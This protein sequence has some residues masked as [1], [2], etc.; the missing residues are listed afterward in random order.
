[1]KISVQILH[2]ILLAGVF[3]ITNVK[4]SY[5]NGLVPKDG[6][7]CAEEIKKV[8]DQYDKNYNR[9]ATFTVTTRS[10]VIE[11]GLEGEWL[12]TVFWKSGERYK[13]DNLFMTVFLD[14]KEHVI[15]LKES[16]V[17][18]VR[19]NSYEDDGKPVGA[20]VNVNGEM[21][22]DSLMALTEDVTC[23]HDREHG[24]LLL[25][26]PVYNQAKLNYLRSAILYYDHGSGAVRKTEYQYRNET[27]ST[28]QV[29]EYLNYSDSPS[30]TVFRGSA[31]DQVAQS[32]TLLPE[33]SGYKIQ[34][35]RKRQAP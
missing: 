5:C 34:D 33:Y 29:T 25:S 15:I 3:S 24:E 14:S 4:V 32:G 27:N 13:L 30:G 22:I 2:V 6:D 1:M 7:K 19:S 17:V 21:D 12:T 31:F 28:V 20:G 8:V 23:A 9:N 35:L 18:I 16:R 26:F 10:L 11:N